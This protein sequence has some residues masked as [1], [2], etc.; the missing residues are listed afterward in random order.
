MVNS[1]PEVWKW[2]N[3]IIYIAGLLGAIQKKLVGNHEGS[4]YKWAPLKT[5]RG[6]HL[7]DKADFLF[8][9]DDFT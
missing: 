6:I 8:P 5:H 3:H 4:A 2:E 9:V 1:V 7:E